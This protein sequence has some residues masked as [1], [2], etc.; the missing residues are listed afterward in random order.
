[1]NFILV[2]DDK[3]EYLTETGYS[4]LGTF[5]TADLADAAARS[6]IDEH[7]RRAYREGMTW[8]Q[9]H[10]AYISVGVEVHVISEDGATGGLFSAWPYVRTR[11]HQLCE[12]NPPGPTGSDA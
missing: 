11:C 4:E 10:A 1:M 8:K 7:L 6:Y 9:L 5:P 3:L 2:I 12:K